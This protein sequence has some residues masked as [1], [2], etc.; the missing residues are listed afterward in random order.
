MTRFFAS[1]AAVLL[2][3]A[4]SPAFAQSQT[5]R[6][7]GVNLL[8]N[9]GFEDGGL[10]TP[11]DWDTTVAGEVDSAFATSPQQMGDVTTPTTYFMGGSAGWIALDTNGAMVWHVNATG[12]RGAAVSSPVVS[13][14][15][16]VVYGIDSGGRVVAIDAHSGAERWHVDLVAGGG[17]TPALV[18]DTLYAVLYDGHLRAINANL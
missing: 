6:S 16:A 1:L 10:F 12:S 4:S 15:G 3:A 11:T 9:G 2:L 13:P 14:D 7:T 18:G 8:S 17:T 5:A